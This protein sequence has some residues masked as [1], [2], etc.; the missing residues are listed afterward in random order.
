MIAVDTNVLMYAHRRDSPFYA[1]A[2]RHLGE[3]VASGHPWAIPWPCVHEFY[4]T[5]T[6]PRRMTIPS[7]MSQAFDQVEIW[8]EAGA[9]FL[10]EGPDHLRVLRGL[11]EAGRI[12][13]PMVH[14]AKIAAICLSHGISELWT[15]DRDFS[16]FP[17]LKTRNPLVGRA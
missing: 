16:R 15:A 5:T 14:D 7:S 12:V 3:L 6:N 1:E 4:N 13:G 17:A 8:A 11:L 2:I 9:V 10:G